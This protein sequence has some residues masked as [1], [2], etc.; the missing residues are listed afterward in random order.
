MDELRKLVPG[1]YYHLYNR[2]NNKENIFPEPENYRYF[3]QLWREHVHPIA[4]TVAYALLKNHFH[5]LVFI[6]PLSDLL[7][8]PSMVVKANDPDDISHK[9]SRRFSD[10][11]NAYAKA[12]NKRYNRTG[13]LFQE[14]FR[15]KL[16]MEED[17]LTDVILYIHTNALKHG[18]VSAAGTYPHTSY[19]SYLSALPTQLPRQKVLG[20][21]GGREAFMAAH[22]QYSENLLLKKMILEREDDDED[23]RTYQQ[24]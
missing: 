11:F 20:R 7:R 14:R 24:T 19:L 22:Q 5:A 15:R 8:L 1:H 2:G 17:Y 9:L 4:E 16:I 18:F 21:F 10:F 3:L 13:S 6:H 12:I 23:V